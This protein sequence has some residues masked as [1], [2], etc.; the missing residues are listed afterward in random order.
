MS[1]VARHAKRRSLGL[2]RAGEAGFTL[3]ELMVTVAVLAILL[4]IAFPSFTAL[5]N[6]NRLT[7]NANALVA[8]LQHARS[9]AVSRN[10]SIV[11]CRSVN[12]TTCATGAQ[13]NGWITIVETGGAVLRVNTVKAPVVVSASSNISGNNDRVVFRP[14]GMARASG[15]ALLN[16]RLAVCIATTR[17]AE[18]QRFVNI[19][20]G[21]RISV[22]RANGAGACAAPGNS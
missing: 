9:E 13:W 2:V 4:A 8:A 22:S 7:G 19:G 16:A 20:T 3:I 10:A 11:V 17:P 5:V 1:F 12:G 21:S 6:S 18:N 14:D 15:G